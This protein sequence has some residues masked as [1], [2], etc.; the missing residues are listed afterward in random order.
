MFALLRWLELKG[1]A[2]RRPLCKTA[3]RIEELEERLVPTLLGQQLFPADY[4]WNQNI[5]NA[6]VAA[7][8]AAIINHIGGSI[9][10]HPDWGNDSASNG[11]SPLYGIPFN[12]V[13]SNAPGTT[14]V[15][16]IID[17]YPGESDVVAVPMPANG[18]VIEGDYQ[19]GPNPN[20]GGYNPGQRGDSHL[21]VWDESTNTAYELYGVT[22]P[23]DPKLFPNTSGVE[24]P[25]NDGQWHA[26]QES[27]WNMN[28]DSFRS[29]GNT[30]ADAAGLS[31]L[32]GLARPDE[33]LP[34]SQ[35]GQ[36]VINHALRFTLPKGDINPQYIY[37]A[38]HVVNAS[39][40]PDNLPFGA[41]LRLMNT[42]QVNA[43]IATMGPQAQII[44]TAMQQYGLVLADVGSPM[45][46]SGASA[47]VNSSNAIDFTWNMNDVLGLH[48]LTASDFQV[49]DLTPV[50]TG[51]S[52]NSGLAGTTVTIT[53]QNFSGAAGHLSV[54]F[55]NTA[56]S[57]VTVLDD[58]HVTA[59]VPSGSGTVNVRVQSGVNAIDPN[60]PNDN[61]NN[62]I[63]GY[64]ISATSAA[65]QFTYSTQTIS[66]ANSTVSFATPSVASGNTDTLTLVVKDT[67]GNAVTGLA[68]GAFGLNLSGGGSG[69][70]FGP[71]S[72]TATPGTYTAVFTATTAGTA[73]TLTTTVSGVTLT[74]KPTVTVTAGA[75]SGSN[76]TASFATPTVASG[77]TDTVTLVVKDAAGNAITGLANGAFGLNLSAGTSAGTFGPVSATAT[78]GTYTA[79]FTPTAVGTASTLTATVNGVVL[80]TKPTVQVIAGGISGANSS[81]SFAAPSVASGNTDTLTIV[82][83]DAAG[84]AITGL[85]NSAFG[86]NLSGGSSGGTFGPVSATATPGTY[87]AVFTGTTAGTASTLS[88]TVG[89]VALASQPTVTVT[90]AVI[91]H[92]GPPPVSNVPTSIVITGL[93][94]RYSLFSQ[95]ETITAR[96][97][98]ANGQPVPSG[99]VRISDN[100][101]TVY[102]SLNNGIATAVVTFALFSEM[103]N[104]H[105]VT[106]FFGGSSGFGASSTS[107]TAPNTML[108]YFF[109]LL[110]F[111]TFLGG[112]GGG[113]SA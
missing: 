67:T 10:I 4:P 60:N 78:P 40:G 62:P 72:A 59:V 13:Q 29:L 47:S 82:V 57:N 110:I 75:V 36:G 77:N 31:I 11:S 96:V 93:Q 92:G 88:V 86:L 91:V 15:N 58:A 32:A 16:V 79:T 22:R 46:V 101:Q 74:T 48:A 39:S 87:T 45:F 107:A 53:G 12:V 9:G 63:F 106:A 2:R 38:S 76:S 83:K 61:V 94:D 34:T 19:N 27:V 65:D 54:P 81:A 20:G 6:P 103:P 68:S 1:T 35:G 17:N 89:G 102:A 99:V 73:S 5:S 97:T 24:L 41:R 44:A 66:A 90:P 64:G 109:Q 49:V 70:T 51:L 37:P 8:S 71:V 50:V 14:K 108:D 85:T 105:T 69:G 28:T 21:L 55:G 104:P 56:A 112:M 7:N 30:S 80:T 3:P 26:A 111:G 100:G 52:T 42:P 113:S 18:V 25:H 43:L 98:G 95:T 84:N 33:G 23:S